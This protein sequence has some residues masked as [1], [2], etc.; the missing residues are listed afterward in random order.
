M[1]PTTPTATA[2]HPELPRCIDFF[3]TE[4]DRQTGRSSSQLPRLKVLGGV[5]VA[6]PEGATADHFGV[7]VKPTHLLR[8]ARKAI[9]A[10]GPHTFDTGG[11]DLTAGQFTEQDLFY[12][13]ELGD[14]VADDEATLRRIL[15]DVEDGPAWAASIAN[16]PD[17]G[18]AFRRQVAEIATPPSGSP[19]AD[20]NAL[21]ALLY[22]HFSYDNQG[23]YFPKWSGQGRSFPAD[24]GDPYRRS[25][26][27][28]A[29][30][31]AGEIYCLGVV[32]ARL[33]DEGADEATMREFL[34]QI[35]Q[36]EP[37]APADGAGAATGTGAAA[38][39]LRLVP[40]YSVTRGARAAG[41][42]PFHQFCFFHAFDGA[43]VL[44][45]ESA[46]TAL[47]PGLTA[48][49]ATMPRV[50]QMEA[51]RD[52]TPEPDFFFEGA[53]ESLKVRTF[54]RIKQGA[55]LQ[56][57]PAGVEVYDLVNGDR[58]PG[59]EESEPTGV[60]Y[61]LCPPDKLVEL[62]A[63]QDVEDLDRVEPVRL[64]LTQVGTDLK[65]ADLRAAQVAS[66]HTGDGNGVMVGVMDSGIDG[67]HPAF[68]GRI[69]AV[70]DQTLP[71]QNAPTVPGGNFGRVL[72]GADI[73]TT[74]VDIIGHGTHVSGIAAGAASPPAY[75]EQGI[76]PRAT[77]AMVRLRDA[78]D[79]ASVVAGAR[80]I[81]QQATNAGLPC[82]INMSFGT[83]I[84]DHDGSDAQAT[85][86]RALI[87]TG[88][89]WRPGRILVAAA[90][91][92]RQKGLH[93]EH[94]NLPVPTRTA[95][96]QAHPATFRRE[97]HP[98]ATAVFRIFVRPGTLGL[99]LFTFFATPVDPAVPRANTAIRV[100]LEPGGGALS[101]PG[102]HKQQLNNNFSLPKRV[103]NT[104]VLISNGRRLPLGIRQSRPV[105]ALV[106][107]QPGLPTDPGVV[108]IDSGVWR[109]SVF[110]DGPSAIEIHGYALRA[111]ADHRA[112][113]RD[114][115]ERCMI[116]SPASGD[117]II[118]VG[119]TV[120]RDSWTRSDGV[121]VRNEL[122]VT[123]INGEVIGARKETRAGLSGFS[124]SGPVRRTNRTLDA[125]A[126]GGGILSAR[127]SQASY[128]PEVIINDR[129]VVNSG[130]SMACPVVT[131]LAACLLEQFPAMDH[132][133]F[134]ARLRTASSMPAGGSP[135]DFGPGIIDS[136]KLP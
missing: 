56:G 5:Y 118:A 131:G 54:G 26:L 117:G 52:A 32:P 83:H 68:A 16:A 78:T 128:L 136:S 37:D 18:A 120:N 35:E 91:N 10:T 66:G 20:P 82:V 130:T 57:L 86:L 81:L 113:F 41:Q 132:P 11:V 106:S 36:G 119:S 104:F 45:P 25:A 129:T 98:E 71:K 21:R 93:V 46:A 38:G 88:A 60:R 43:G 111:D 99:A 7:P 100:E 89:G 2:L 134:Q 3:F 59:E 65:T 33:L 67:T 64:S 23:N 69:H 58:G 76:A 115:V 42:P 87:R 39:V 101:W 116:A 55:T 94:L 107:R 114:G 48:L 53:G 15:A 85:Q 19:S 44:I 61:F 124:N 96:E 121:V 31:L 9:R 63:H 79:T 30:L 17:R 8:V 84:N 90:G 102:W 103:A 13:H 133:N 62:A 125:V 95:A 72:R 4:L 127:S 97:N 24:V 105:V 75:T 50:E 12:L 126:P 92:E 47:Q 112:F 73:A 1:A 108:P 122:E 29:S 51:Y 74:S 109:V 110:N 123:D 40:V 34:V 77:L 27:R 22:R 80:W 28:E 49:L 14:A 6:V 70:W 135:D